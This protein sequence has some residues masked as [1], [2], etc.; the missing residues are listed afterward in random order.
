MVD[1]P[2]L[3]SLARRVKQLELLFITLFLYDNDDDEEETIYEL[4]RF[5]RRST[6]SSLSIDLSE[7]E[8]LLRNRDR[9]R[10]SIK[11]ESTLFNQVKHLE[12]EI[13]SLKNKTE[14]LQ[15]ETHSMLALQAMGIPDNQVKLQRF[16]PVRAY[17]DETPDGAIKAISSAIKEVLSAYG[18]EV[19]DEFPE[20]KGSW[21]KKWFVKSKDTLSRPEVT[22]RLDKVERAIELQVL[23]RP[24]AD[25]DE[26]QSSAI[27][28]LIKALENVPNAAI[29][30]GSVLVVKLTTPNGPVIQARTLSQD[31]MV[32]LENNQLLLQ[33][34][35]KVLYELSAACLNSRKQASSKLQNEDIG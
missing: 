8:F 9:T 22:E 3:E 6:K 26:K 15:S 34:P 28:N 19:A 35:S 11:S 7:I 5:F 10:N 21:F 12:G 23:N 24:Q 30:S 32:Q 18:F 1:K 31:E 17:I 33:E 14:L 27:A 13:K 16:I 4:Q 29:Q 20:I 25:I 2:N